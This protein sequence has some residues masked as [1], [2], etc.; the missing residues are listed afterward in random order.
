MQVLFHESDRQNLL[1]LVSLNTHVQEGV[2]FFKGRLIFLRL[3][4]CFIVRAASDVEDLI[5]AVFGRHTRWLARLN[6]AM[7]TQD[8]LGNHAVAFL[9]NVVCNDKEQ[10]ETRQQRVWQRNI[11]ARFLVHVVLTINGIRSGN[12]GAASI[13]RS[14]DTCLGDRHRLL[15][16]DFVDRDAVHIRHLVKLVNAHDAAIRQNHSTRL[17][18]PLTCFAIGRDGCSQTN[19]TAATARRGNR[20]RRRVQHEA[21]HLTLGGGWITH[22]EDVDI[23]TNVCAICEVLL[24]ATEEH[25]QDGALQVVV[26]KDGRSERLGEQVKHVFPP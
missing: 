12:D 9:V 26:P 20:Q 7:H 4:R 18:T 19:T 1:P 3:I 5:E 21:Q 11:P 10:V 22:H 14:V 2:V 16:H 8:M 23:A 25:E 24:L 17:E 15:L 6:V 13:E